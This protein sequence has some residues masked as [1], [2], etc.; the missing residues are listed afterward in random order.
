[1]TVPAV[2]GKTCGGANADVCQ[3]TPPWPITRDGRRVRAT[4]GR[5]RSMLSSDEHATSEGDGADERS[6]RFD[7]AVPARAGPAARAAERVGP[8]DRTAGRRGRVPGGGDQFGGGGRVARLPRPRGRGGGG[9][10]RRGS[11]D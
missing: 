1:M 2:P 8:G 9:D 5:P 11:P 10:V 3:D 4:A 7:T 6:D